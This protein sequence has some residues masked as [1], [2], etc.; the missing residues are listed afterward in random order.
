MCL[1]QLWDSPWGFGGSAKGCIDGL[2]FKIGKITIFLIILS[3]ILAF[4]F[5]KYKESLFAVLL[6]FVAFLFSIFMTVFASKFIW[7]NIPVMAFFQYPWRFLV[8]TTLFSSLLIGSLFTKPFIILR[9]KRV[10]NIFIAFLLI[11]AVVFFNAKL[12][13]PQYVYETS[14][15]E[16]TSSFNVK[17][18]A[19]KISDEYLPKNFVKPNNY[20]ETPNSYLSSDL[21]IK[22]HKEETDE[23]VATIHSNKKQ[24]MTTSIA[25]FPFWKVYVNKREQNYINEKGRISILLEKGSNEVNI[26]IGQTKV[27]KVSNIIS[28][29]GFG[30]LLIG[31]I[32]K[33]GL[34]LR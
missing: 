7:N 29:V 2:S 21:P 13:A 22:I 31:I 26:K 27:E 33:R 30:V 12:F 8:F 3:F 5:R 14:S 10:N 11:G 34:F 20:S 25:Y 28:I 6:F 9:G 19:S 23:I 4:R 32:L 17:W 16:L 15:E 24:R 18:T 1:S